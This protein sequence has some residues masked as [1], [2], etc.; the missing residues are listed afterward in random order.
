MEY[1]LLVAC[2]VVAVSVLG[3]F[4]VG[5]GP[6]VLAVGDAPATTTTTV[7]V[8]G[9]MA[10]QGGAGDA[11]LWVPGDAGGD[12]EP[13]LL[14]AR[15]GA[16]LALLD[17]GRLVLDQVPLPGVAGVDLRAGFGGEPSGRAL[18]V[19]GDGPA[20]RAYRLDTDALRLTP[21]GELRAG[22]T[23][24]GL[25]LGRIPGTGAV[26]AFAFDAAGRIV[27]WHL[28]VAAG[29]DVVARRV[30]SF[31]VGGPVAACVADDASGALF[32]SE[33]GR[34]LWR[35]PAAAGTGPG[36]GVLVDE[37]GPG[38]L[39]AAADAL[40]VID[41]AD[42]PGWIL[43]SSESD[44][45]FTFYR[46]D[47]TNAAAGRFPVGTRVDRCQDTTGL[48]VGGGFLVCQG[49]EQTRLVPLEDVTRLVS[50]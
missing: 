31:E 34:G 32:V 2:A 22:L 27:H 50:P 43:A 45:T 41:S 17:A 35:F 25:C 29:G 46:R 14:A 7:E 48:D 5:L 11:A 49:P 8:L 4:A 16:G 20:L 12:P 39:V 28:G 21:M 10:V 26:H 15:P 24:A 30:R 13:L 1:L 6:Q 33:R 3:R 19:A 40:A 9:Q 38:G 18:V 47:D 37:I 44:E 42:G 23:V 36:A